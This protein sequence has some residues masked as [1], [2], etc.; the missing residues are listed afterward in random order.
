MTAARS[1]TRRDCFR[2]I[3]SSDFMNKMPGSNVT[4]SGV[5]MA[6]M[7]A[8]SLLIGPKTA[9]IMNSIT[10]IRIFRNTMASKARAF[11]A[12][13]IIILQNQM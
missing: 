11:D 13:N 5:T 6:T 10:P 7:R 4:P 12:Y 3:L 1:Q 8:S 9:S 2:P